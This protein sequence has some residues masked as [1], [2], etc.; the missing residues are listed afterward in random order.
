MRAHLANQPMVLSDT[1]VQMTASF[2][3][4]SFRPG[5]LSTAEQ[6]I[7]R[8]DEALYRAKDLGRNRVEYLDSGEDAEATAAKPEI[9]RSTA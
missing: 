7:R 5:A 1:T 4:T 8:A 9:A 3:G 2:G 6:L